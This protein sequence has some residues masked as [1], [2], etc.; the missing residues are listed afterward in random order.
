MFTHETKQRV[1]YG[2]TDKMGYL[3][4]GRYADFYEIGRV[5]AM[6][7]LGIS[8]QSM[9]DDLGVL[10]PVIKLEMKFLKPA[11]YDAELRIRTRLHELP[12]KMI[13]FHGE[14]FNEE[15]V[16]IN[17]AIIKL[18]FID[19]ETGKRLSCPEILLNELKGYFGK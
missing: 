19:K 11:Y 14:I 15:N 13:E 10:L 16:S 12:G 18:F 4:Y 2:Q 7:H 9:E 17:K 5:E 6:R 3:Y 8:Y 1:R